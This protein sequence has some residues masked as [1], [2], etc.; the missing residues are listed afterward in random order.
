MQITV[1]FQV[2]THTSHVSLNIAKLDEF[3]AI[4]KQSQLIDYMK[5]RLLL[6]PQKK[7][8]FDSPRL[9]QFFKA[10]VNP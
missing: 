3:Q 8:E 9:H 10:Q 5:L 2:V 4:T 7:V 6:L 1:C